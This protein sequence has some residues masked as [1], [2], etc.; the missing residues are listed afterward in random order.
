MCTRAP[1]PR[2]AGE[3]DTYGEDAL[4][5]RPLTLRGHDDAHAL[6]GCDDRAVEKIA[7]PATGSAIRDMDRQ[8]NDGRVV[9]QVDR[10]CWA[11]LGPSETAKTAI[12]A[13]VRTHAR[14][15]D[16]AISETPTSKRYRGTFVDAG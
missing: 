5:A 7:A 2:T 14:E 9:V 11:R 3:L 15:N 16:I 1:D 8:E 6:A 13:E 4:A 10:T 12:T